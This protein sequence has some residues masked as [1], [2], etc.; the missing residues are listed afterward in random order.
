MLQQLLQTIATGE[1]RDLRVL[2]QE[3][4]TNE[5]LLDD[6]LARL[7]Q[8]GYLKRIADSGC[9]ECSHCAMKGSC[10]TS[11]RARTWVLTE[12]GR[13]AAQPPKPR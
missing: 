10:V 6:M 3:M 7:V 5:A 13:R 2:A 4:D 1:V 8:M 11:G 12:A 9:T